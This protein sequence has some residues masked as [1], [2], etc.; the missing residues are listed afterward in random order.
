MGIKDFINRHSDLVK[1]PITAKLPKQK[2][3]DSIPT[4]GMVQETPKE[5][6]KLDDLTTTPKS[7]KYAPFAKLATLIFKDIKL[8]MRSKSSSLI[9]IFGPLLLIFLVGMAFN[10]SS[11]YDLR[12]AT[13]SGAYSELSNSIIEDLQDE[14]YSTIRTDILE[15]CLDGV[16]LGRFHACTVFSPNMAI[17]NEAQNIITIKVDESRMNLA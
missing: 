2:L 17:G 3:Q 9:I 12:I 11:L 16:K 7:L 1:K 6:P 4:P 5:P 13:Y 14:Q 15:D 10:T 8:L